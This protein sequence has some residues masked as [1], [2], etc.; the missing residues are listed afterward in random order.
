MGEFDAST[1]PARL[2]SSRVLVVGAGGL[3]CEILKDLAM[4]GV[5]NID[6]ID[7]DTIDVT[8]L[9]RQFLFRMKDVGSSKAVAAASFIKNRCPWINIVAHHGKIQD[10]VSVS[11]ASAEQLDVARCDSK[12][13]LN[14]FTLTHETHTI[15]L[16]LSP[17][18]PNNTQHPPPTLP[19]PSSSTSPLT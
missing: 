6:V 9:N 3:G 2:A 17:P 14:S 12:L 18:S 4:S 19:S 1:A 15:F 7:L 13:S 8:N 16:P 11:A 10:K 5:N